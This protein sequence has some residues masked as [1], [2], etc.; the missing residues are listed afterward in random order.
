MKRKNENRQHKQTGFRKV[1]ERIGSYSIEKLPLLAI[2]LFLTFALFST[3]VLAA[4]NP[5][6]DSLYI[7]RNGDAVS[8]DINI[9]GTLSVAD[10]WSASHSNGTIN[11]GRLS[12]TPATITFDSSQGT[13]G[14]IKMSKPIMVP[15]A[16]PAITFYDLN[17]PEN[18]SKFKSIV[19]DAANG[20]IQ[21]GDA[22]TANF[23]AGD[24]APAAG[25][26]LFQI[27]KTAISNGDSAGTFLGI[28]TPANFNGHLLMIQKGGVE[29]VKITNHGDLVLTSDLMTGNGPVLNTWQGWNNNGITFTNWKSNIQDTASAANSL[30]LDMQV[31]GNSKLAV[32]KDGRVTAE[33]DFC[34]EGGACLSTTASGSGDVTGPASSTDN[35]I[36]RFDGT[37]GKTLQNSGIKI[38]DTDQLMHINNTKLYGYILFDKN[39]DF[40]GSDYW[41][42][43][44]ATAG[45]NLNVYY[46]GIG[47]GNQVFTFDNDGDVGIGVADPTRRL[48]VNGQ[49]YAESATFPVMGFKRTTA[50]TGGPL[51]SFTGLSSAMGLYTKTSGNMTDGFGGGIVFYG[52]DNANVENAVAR[53]YARRDGADDAGAFQIWTGTSGSS[54][55]TTFRANGNVGI[56]IVNPGEKL[57][58]AGNINAT[59]DV[60]LDDGTCLSNAAAGASEGKVGV[61]GAATPDYL[62]ATG[63]TGALH[64]AGPISYTDGGNFVTLGITGDSI[65]NS[66]LE[67]DTGQ[68]LTTSS[69]PT[70]SGAII[71]GNLRVAG[72][73]Q[74]ILD[75][76]EVRVSNDLELNGSQLPS[77]SDV[78]DIGSSTKKWGTM[79]IKTA[80]DSDGTVLST[81]ELNV[82]DGG[83]T[84]GEV[85][86]TVGDAQI[87][88]NAVDGGD[89]GEIADDTITT[90]DIAN[91]TIAAIDIAPNAVT[92][93]ELADNSVDLGAISD[94]ICA[95]GELLKKA[96]G[97]WTCANESLTSES[98]TLATVTGRGATTTTAVT[99]D[100]NSDQTT[101]VANTLYVKGSTDTVGIGISNPSGKLEVWKADTHTTGAYTGRGNLL[102]YNNQNNA[103][104]LGATLIFGSHYNDGTQQFT[105]RAGI[106]GGTDTAGNT[107]DGYLAF[108]TATGS[109][110]NNLERARFDKDGDFG[111]GL[112]NPQQKLHVNGNARIDGRA[113]VDGDINVT[114]GNDICITGGQCLSSVAAGTVTGSGAANH[115]AYWSDGTTVA[116]DTNQLYW[117]ASANELGIG[118]NTPDSIL[119]VGPIGTGSSNYITIG[120]GWDSDSGIKWL[121]DTFV[122]ASIHQDASEDLIFEVDMTGNLNS[123]VIFKTNGGQEK[124]RI[125]EPGNLGIGVNDPGQKLEVNGGVR[126]NTA[127]AKPACNAAVRGTMWFEQQGTGVAD[128][129]YVCMKNAADGYNWVQVAIGS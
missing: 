1:N 19:Y 65:G 81:S 40:T 28:N 38:D 126:L 106:K 57:E 96:G 77:V 69:S 9:S 22:F 32:R 109:A 60:C 25:K 83:I 51:T 95:N 36:V 27:G 37:G 110:N 105:S 2:A 31:G 72:T 111:I 98:D 17:D 4:N 114:S 93:S 23:G 56:G 94:S 73:G 91:N 75:S 80:I 7:K 11:L 34:I 58:V 18:T 47:V 97:D 46:G 122:D 33:N 50:V 67:F 84:F 116:A 89:G 78:F 85:G 125:T 119:H 59:G 5:G 107:A 68:A 112:T 127:T 63:S 103:D 90:D 20:Q 82:L 70:F 113:K 49:I 12:D 61:D 87:A 129:M 128:L 35:A 13:N 117:D 45:D 76:G 42:M 39:G 3:A 123:N 16:S 100:S 30:L 118:T 108:Y 41:A 101:N 121:R 102:L 48:Q 8:A 115:I 104:E 66:Q 54:Y 99:I 62:G 79:Y 44:Q 124:V 55:A 74:L 21:T 6:H 86:G 53:L 88:D 15:G 120:K 43:Q 92:A 71:N 64:V 26:T 10:D 29:Q 52:E 24:G 14:K